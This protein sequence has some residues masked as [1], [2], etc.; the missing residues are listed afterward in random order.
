MKTNAR[1]SSLGRRIDTAISLRYEVQK[2]RASSRGVLIDGENLRICVGLA[3]TGSKLCHD[4]INNWI[5]HVLRQ[6]ERIAFRHNL[7]CLAGGI[8]KHMAGAALG[9]MQ[10]EFLAD[11]RRHLILEVVRELGEKLLA[12]DHCAAPLLLPTR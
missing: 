5:K 4:A 2:N 9:Q 1:G 7:D 8:V 12:C 6:L 3:A 10:F 11:L